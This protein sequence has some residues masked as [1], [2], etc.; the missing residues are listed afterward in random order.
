[1][2]RRCHLG[3]V[4]VA[5]ASITS[6]R[7]PASDPVVYVHVVDAKTGN[8]ILRGNLEMRRNKPR[9]HERALKEKIGPDGTAEFHLDDPPPVRVRIRLG[10]SMGYWYGCSQ[11]SYET[12]EVLQHGAS[13]KD[14]ISP[15]PHVA[16]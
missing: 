10:K 1:M 8:A 16:R 15:S 13:E 14:D 2:T 11:G 9:E 6:L 12:N 4:V 5:F 7:C 3:V